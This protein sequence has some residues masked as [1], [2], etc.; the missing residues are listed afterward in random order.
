MPE[1]LGYT[2]DFL[3]EKKGYFTAK[4][5]EQQPRVW[6][7]ILEVFQNGEEKIN[8]FIARTKNIENLRVILTGAG[9]S[10]YIGKMLAPYLSKK[11]S[12]RFEAIA[13]TEIVTDPKSYLKKDIPTLLISY[14]RSGNSPESVAT[15]ELA[16]QMIDK[17]YQI[18]ITCNPDGELAKKAIGDSNILLFLMP[19]STND[20]GFAMTSSFSTMVLASLLLFENPREIIPIV[21]K[22]ANYGERILGRYA[23]LMKEMSNEEV[24]RVLFLGSS[25]L[26]GLAKE[27]ALK[28]MEL[29]KGKVIGMSESPL[30]LRHG[31][32]TVIDDKTLIFFYLSNH[33]YTARYE[34]D[35][36]NEL[37]SERKYFKLVVISSSPNKVLMEKAD[38]FFPIQEIEDNMMIEDIYLSLIYVL[39]AQMY[40]FSRSLRLGITP[41]NPDPEGT[42]NRVVKG[43]TI[44]PFQ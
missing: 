16:K 6:R 44:Y 18:V 17:L 8:Q 26:N 34:I 4:E 25:V 13:T 2:E 28:V 7:E 20:K 30:G 27:S 40:A 31:P 36:V 39:F 43:V 3:R 14:A 1:I 5:I 41:D 12:R 21:N 22:V 11:Y 19:D 15:V 42:V 35:L 23:S 9:T 38:A 10:A 24:N 33:P 32:K 37:S 29:T